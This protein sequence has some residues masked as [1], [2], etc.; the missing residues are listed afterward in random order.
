[1]IYVNPA[2]YCKDM[3]CICA[4]EANRGMKLDFKSK[5][6]RT[7][8]MQ[9]RSLIN[10]SSIDEQV[11]LSENRQLTPVSKTPWLIDTILTTAK[12][13]DFEIDK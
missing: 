11:M 3:Q 4:N 9:A 12:F 2:K 10:L 8:G 1:M 6:Q 5:R 13:H 7:L